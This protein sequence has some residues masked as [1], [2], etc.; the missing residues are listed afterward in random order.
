MIDDLDRS[1]QTLLTRELPAA[2]A[3][4]LTITFAPPDGEFPP[5]TVPLPAVDLFLYDV[6]DNRD[7]HTPEWT[8]ARQSDGRVLRTPPPARVDCAYLVTAWT[9]TTGPTPTFD[10]HRILG[11]V[12]RVLLRHRTLPEQVLQGVMAEQELPLPTATLQP[13]SLRGLSEFWQALGGKTKTTLN[14][15]VTISVPLGLPRPAGP[16]AT[17]S[18]M[19]LQSSSTIVQLP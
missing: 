7:L 14:Y 15:T 3:D 17:R 18:R 10:E 11:E 5:S 19:R 2:L 6:R 12:M 9:V 13:G 1:L 16:P 4:Q 8:A